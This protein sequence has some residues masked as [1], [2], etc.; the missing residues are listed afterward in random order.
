MCIRDR[1]T[2]PEGTTTKITDDDPSTLWVR[3]GDKYPALLTLDLGKEEYVD[4]LELYF[5]DVY[6]RQE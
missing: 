4:V 3:N 6:K 1:V 2:T 5:E